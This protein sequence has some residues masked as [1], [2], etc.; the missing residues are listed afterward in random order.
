MA[1]FTPTL[2]VS[3]SC[4]SIQYQNWTSRWQRINDVRKSAG[5]EQGH[6]FRKMSTLEKCWLLQSIIRRPE[7][8]EFSGIQFDT[9][10]IIIIDWY[11]PLWKHELI[12]LTTRVLTLSLDRASSPW[13]DKPTKKN[14]MNRLL[15]PEG[16]LGDRLTNWGRVTRICASKLTI[17][18]SEAASH[19]LNQWWNRLVS[20][21]RAPLTACGELAGKFW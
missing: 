1:L 12:W 8:I 10:V 15:S 6:T 3:V 17:K 9:Y 13:E 18:D 19:Y 20:Q 7:Q 16:S 11:F 14:E 21:M 2:Q 5:T 4:I